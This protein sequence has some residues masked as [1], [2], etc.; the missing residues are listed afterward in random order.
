MSLDI[1]MSTVFDGKNRHTSTALHLGVP[2]TTDQFEKDNKV[3]GIVVTPPHVA[4]EPVTV[5]GMAQC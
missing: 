5:A 1:T 3:R 4:W 2:H